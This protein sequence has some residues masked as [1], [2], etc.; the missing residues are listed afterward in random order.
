MKLFSEKVTEEKYCIKYYIK[1]NIFGQ[2]YIN[3]FKE[4]IKIKI[5][6]TWNENPQVSSWLE[7]YDEDFFIKR[8]KCRYFCGI[9]LYVLFEKVVYVD[10]HLIINSACF[11]DGINYENFWKENNLLM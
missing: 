3:E 8:S 10:K 6:T 1:R 5:K 4:Y 2:Y 7:F 11:G 9:K